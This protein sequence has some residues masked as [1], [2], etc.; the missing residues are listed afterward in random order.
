[1]STIDYPVDTPIPLPKLGSWPPAVHV[2]APQERDAL[3]AA[4][5]ANR[6]LLVRGE[7]GTGK[8]QLARAA[9]VAR[10][11][12]FLSVV[13]HARTE[14]QDLQWYFDAVGRLGEAQILAYVPDADV[15]Q[16]LHPRRFL[17]PGPLWWVFDWASAQAQYQ[18]CASPVVPVPPHPEGWQPSH[19]SV[20]L[21]DEIDKADTDLA[22]GLLETLGNSDFPVPYGQTSVRQS[23]DSPAPLVII[24]TNEERELPAAFLRRCLVLHLSLPEA[25][26]DLLA[27]LCRRG[28][29]HFRD[30]CSEAVRQHAAHLLLRDRKHASDQG[31]PPP[32]Q[33]EYLDLLR[34]VCTMAPADEP[35]QLVLLERLGAFVLQKS[36]TLRS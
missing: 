8:S 19:G 34:A 15:R 21:L 1:M 29:V 17:S 23:A 18:V 27:L 14:C 13:V 9:A 2:F 33:A 4:E 28:V 6:P 25:E 20:L 3:L 7:P 24:T 30:Q 16:H 35:A 10:G 26:A 5:A 31:L 32:G 36:P 22:N 11:R 12:L